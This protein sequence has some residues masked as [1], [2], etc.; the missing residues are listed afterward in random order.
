MEYT[1]EGFGNRQH[2]SVVDDTFTL[3]YHPSK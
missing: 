1:A 2:R 3:P